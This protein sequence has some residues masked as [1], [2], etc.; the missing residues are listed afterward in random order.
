MK[1]YW[2]LG[3]TYL[4]NC[5][6]ASLP[7]HPETDITATPN[8]STSNEQK[9]A[10]KPSGGSLI[11][12]QNAPIG[13]VRLSH[14]SIQNA[15]TYEYDKSAGEGITVYVLDGG[16]WH[17]HKE[18]E[19]RATFGKKFN[20]D[21]GT[22]DYDGH[23]T[24]IAGI[25]GGVTFGV[26]K[27]VKII[28][29][30]LDNNATQM[31]QA[32]DFV[33][34][35]VKKRQIQGKAVVSMSMH[36]RASDELDKKF[37]ELTEAGVVCVVSAGN[38]GADAG[39]FSPGRDPSVITVAAI[40]AKNDITW[41]HSN[42]GAA[43]DIWAHGVL[44]KSASGA[45]DASRI[46]SGTSQATPQVAGLAAYIMALEGITKPKE[47][48]DRLKLLAKQSGATAWWMNE[49]K[50]TTLIASNGADKIPLK[51]TKP[52]KIPWSWGSF[53]C[54]FRASDEYCGTSTY[55]DAFKQGSERNRSRFFRDEQECLSA[56]EPKPPSPAGAS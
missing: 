48:A 2:L 29:V 25:I 52:P 11:S 56:H 44:V 34:E 7:P 55:C 6:A 40:D 3:G 51:N 27:K 19:G 50:T 32:A 9:P 21:P 24:H 18:F 53:R 42:Y 41:E 33:L 45:N 39:K 12:Q 28:S 31:M 37:R 43:V 30:K 22:E 5:M 35:D 8:N 26:A 10:A 47:V 20:E 54:L 46:D 23:G 17:S 38:N 1:L 16:I 4:S 49:P 15:T 36:Q 14:N 13:L